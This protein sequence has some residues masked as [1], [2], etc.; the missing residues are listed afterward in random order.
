MKKHIYVFALAA[1]TFAACSNS[2]KHEDKKA[3]D[4]EEM[5]DNHNGDHDDDEHSMNESH[6]EHDHGSM[7]ASNDGEMMAEDMMVQESNTSA[8]IVKAYLEIKNALVNDDDKAA[9]KGGKNLMA[10]F[11]AFDKTTVSDDKK[12][13]L[14]DII[15]N[16]NEQ[17]EHIADNEGNIAHQREHLLVLSKDI[18]DLVEI[19]GTNQ[20]LYAEF[21]PMYAKNGGMWLSAEKEI[22][23]PF[24]GSKMLKCGSVKSTIAVK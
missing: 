2:G 18:K 24:F 23:N 8:G 11:S 20:T 15:A 22:R 6:G 17:A 7:S 13:E 21:C 10:A 14:N 16:A 5:H 12:S 19:T 4:K 9:A 3:S 1:F